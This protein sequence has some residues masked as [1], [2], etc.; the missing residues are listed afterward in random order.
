MPTF[1]NRFSRVRQSSVGVT[2]Y[3]LGMH[4]ALYHASQIFNILGTA[5]HNMDSKIQSNHKTLMEENNRKHDLGCE[6]KNSTYSK[7]QHTNQTG[8]DKNMF[9]NGRDSTDINQQCAANH[10]LL[11]PQNDSTHTDETYMRELERDCSGFSIKNHCMPYINSCLSI[12]LLIDILLLIGL[13]NLPDCSLVKTLLSALK[14]LQHVFQVWQRFLLTKQTDHSAVTPFLRNDAYMPASRNPYIEQKPSCKTA[15][16]LPDSP[17]L[18]SIR[19]Q[20]SVA[21]R[22]GRSVTREDT[23]VYDFGVN[24]SPSPVFP[25]FPTF[26]ARGQH[27]QDHT[28]PMSPRTRR[29][30]YSLLHKA[31]VPNRQASYS[32]VRHNSTLNHQLRVQSPRSR[33]A[34]S[35]SRTV[36]SSS[37]SRK[38]THLTTTTR[39]RTL[40]SPRHSTSHS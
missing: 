11:E 24:R 21:D 10:S 38:A 26:A 4:V 8:S 37:G 12:T 13:S 19:S 2:S 23:N 7:P 17:T 9:S 36:R 31:A 28:R 3:T 29:T 35:H 32:P 16:D 22:Q 14:Y 20:T 27:T 5:G 18:S 34:N 40:A 33:Q 1:D 15:C 25:E 6:V 30:G 39:G